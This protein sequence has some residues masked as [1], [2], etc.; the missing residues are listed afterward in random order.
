MRT[1][2]CHTMWHKKTAPFFLLSYLSVFCQFLAHIYFSDYP[3]TC[4]LLKTCKA[5]KQPKF[6]QYSVPAHNCRADSLQDVGLRHSFYSVSPNFPGFG[7]L[8]YIIL[9]VLEEA[10]LSAAAARCWRVEAMSV[11]QSN[12]QHI[13]AIDPEVDQWWL[14]MRVESQADSLN[15]GVFYYCCWP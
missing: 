4:I 7:R 14:R 6:Q 8:D 15:F 2:P 1:T 10:G 9:E 5:E 11:R 3:I 13:M 12:I